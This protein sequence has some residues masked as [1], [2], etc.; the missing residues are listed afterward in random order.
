M[1]GRLIFEEYS[2]PPNEEVIHL[3]L[4]HK[5]ESLGNLSYFKHWKQWV[6]DAHYDTIYSWDCLL[7]ISNKLKELNEQSKLK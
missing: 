3:V 6:F 1:K 7:E 5:R 2:N 4:N